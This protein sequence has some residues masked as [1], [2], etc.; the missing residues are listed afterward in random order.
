MVDLSE[1]EL[2]IRQLLFT[3]PKTREELKQWV[4]FFLNIELP[5]VIVDPDSN[6]TML[7]MVWECY[8]HLMY[9][10]PEEVS[11]ILY[12]SCRFGGKTL[13][14]SILEVMLLL[15]FRSKIVHLAA[16]EEQSKNCQDYIK[17]FLSLPNL[18]GFVVSDSVTVTEVCFYIPLSSD[19]IYLMHKEW[20]SLSDPEKK[21]YKKVSN[22][23]EVIKATMQ[24]TN[25]KHAC[26]LVLDEIDVMTQIRVL[27][28]AVNIP[29]PSIRED[30]TTALP[31][32][33]NTS[34]RKT[35]FGP[36]QDMINQADKTGLIIRHWNIIDITERC[37]PKRHLPDQPKLEC[38]RSDEYLKTI[39][40][41]Q[42]ELLPPKDK[43]KYEKDMCFAGCMKNCRLFAVC[44]GRLVDKQTSTSK[45]LKPIPYVIEQ[46]KKNTLENAVAQLMCRKASSTGLIYPS[47]SKEKHMISPAQA[48]EIITGEQPSDCFRLV[49]G[50]NNEK[51][52][53]YDPNLYTKEM[54][55]KWVMTKDE[56]GEYR[57][58]IGG[59]MDFGFT[60]YFS[61]YG[62]FIANNK[63]FLSFGG[64]SEGLE[65]SQQLEFMDI[66]KNWRIPVWPDTEDPGHIRM[67]RNAGFI[68][69]EW[70]K[71]KGKGAGSGK[72]GGSVITGINRMRR[73]IKPAFDAPPE[74][75][76][77]HDVGEDPYMD[78]LF[79]HLA[80]HHFKLDATGKPT[81]I[82]A[83]EKKD[84][85]D[86]VRYYVMNNFTDQGKVIV[87]VED[88]HPNQ[89]DTPV[90]SDGER[91][92]AVNSWMTQRINELTGSYERPKRQ[93]M[94]I[95]VVSNYYEEE[96]KLQEKKRKG[97]QSSGICFDFT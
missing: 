73:K 17:N 68:M 82:V 65:P 62:G 13:G 47:L 61:F 8:S 10:G 9:G 55:L 92:Y 77:I 67:F 75:Y 12:Y 71:N 66:Y 70:S 22:S 74:F 87:G 15:H 24:S 51:I 28:E 31:L 2:E 97:G 29:T 18:N 21:L 76:I 3:T 94:T 42:Y 14:E 96:N 50:P 7:N 5:D 32:T 33:I 43:T 1:E 26:V 36:V 20:N 6:C 53:E 54:L 57:F 39:T 38:Y 84:I 91:V 85:P 56:S 30:G 48:Y 64:A 35:S 72:T 80:E 83:D 95:E 90:N 19:G 44:K 49:D 81:N 59:G 34:T 89:I 23:C 25:G 79:E 16:I 4:Y 69:K 58:P 93:G 11:S 63:V 41:Q 40:P 88:R 60:H 45:L 27:A 78:L 37:A 52:K 86:S 46:F